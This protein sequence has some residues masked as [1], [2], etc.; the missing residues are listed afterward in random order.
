MGVDRKRVIDAMSRIRATANEDGIIPSFG[1][2]VNQ[3][4][5]TFWNTF[6]E[7][8]TRQVGPDLLEAAEFLLVNAATECG[9]H[10]G[11]GIMASEEWKA[12]VA[13]MVEKREDVLD[14]LFAV[15][16]SWG[17]G[18]CEVVDLSPGE[19]MVVR[20]YDYYESDV[21]T[22]GESSK[23]SA[24]MLRGVCAAFMVVAYRGEYVPGG[25][26]CLDDYECEQTRGIECGDDYGE[27]IV[28]R[29]SGD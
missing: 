2:F 19:R 5:V 12:V 14:G 27:F 18:R 22:Y 17:W 25:K 3:L 10:T 20:A 26:T 4:P 23:K 11:H 29:Y 28:T 15:V 6:S 21:V 24:Y 8:L 13:P 9:Y 1:V 7:R 16:T